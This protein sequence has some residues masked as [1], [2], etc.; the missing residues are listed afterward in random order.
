[1]RACIVSAWYPVSRTLRRIGNELM[2]ALSGIPHAAPLDA[3]G[4]YVKTAIKDYAYDKNGN[5]TSVKEYDRVPF[6]S[7]HDASGSP[8]WTAARPAVVRETAAGY[9]AAT[10]DASDSSTYD[11]DAYHRPTS[12]RKRDATSWTEA[13]DASRTL[14]RTEFF[15]DDPATKGNLTQRKTWDSKQGAYSNPLGASNSISTATQYDLYGNPTLA[16][17]GRGSQT[18]LTYGAV[19]AHADLHPTIRPTDMESLWVHF[20]RWASTPAF[21]RR[22]MRCPRQPPAALGQSKSFATFPR[23]RRVYW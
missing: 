22:V 18:K 17:D 19:G 12:P 13:R 14:S 9:Y 4:A 2:V 20:Q 23:R 1:M 5:V 10:L 3:T 11:A 7:V 8:L 21:V 15:Y 6:T 16:T